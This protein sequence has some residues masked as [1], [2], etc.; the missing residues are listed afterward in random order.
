[1]CNPEH[2]PQVGSQPKS[3]EFRCHQDSWARPYRITASMVACLLATTVLLAFS[4]SRADDQEVSL[5]VKGIVVDEQE[6]PVAGV[7]VESISN[8][9]RSGT[10]SAKDGTFS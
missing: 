9:E 10:V 4:E 7:R 5:T 6:Q 2:R 3:G 8:R 1:M